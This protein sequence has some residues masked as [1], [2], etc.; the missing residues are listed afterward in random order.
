[1]QERS[2]NQISGFREMADVCGLYDLGL[3][4]QSW[5]F[6]KLVAGGSY[7]RVR[8]DRAL[9]TPNW[10]SLF[11]AATVS[12]LSAASSDHGPILLRWKQERDRHSRKRKNRFH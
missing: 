6:E 12:H 1:V 4:G 3:E 11:P 8:L 9:A 5:T 2:Y 10:N 7:C